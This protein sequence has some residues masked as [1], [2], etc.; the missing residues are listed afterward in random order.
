MVN[1]FNEWTMWV[2]TEVLK[3]Q[4]PNMRAMVVAHFIKVAQ[5]CREYHNYHSCYAIIAGLNYS[6][7]SRYI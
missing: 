7:V 3:K 2:V 6:A 5:K 1:K 4:K